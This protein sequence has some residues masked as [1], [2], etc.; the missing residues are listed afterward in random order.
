MPALGTDQI[1][2]FVGVVNPFAGLHVH[3]RDTAALVVGEVNKT[4]A[5]AQ[6]LLPW[7]DPATA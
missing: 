4:A 6:A 1:N 2:L 7:Q 3:E 5:A